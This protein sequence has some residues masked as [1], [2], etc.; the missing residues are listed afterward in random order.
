[1]LQPLLKRFGRGYMIQCTAMGFDYQP[2]ILKVSQVTSDG[3]FADFEQLRQ[4]SHFHPLLGFQQ[5]ENLDLSL[6]SKKTYFIC[7][8][9]CQSA[10]QRHWPYVRCG[11]HRSAAVC[12]SVPILS[13][14]TPT[15]TCPP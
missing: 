4:P 6:F 7:A 13:I 14:L 5:F 3:V 9:E 12:H 8:H 1:M 10:V 2:L 15:E 11:G